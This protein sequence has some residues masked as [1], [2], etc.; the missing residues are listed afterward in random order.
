MVAALDQDGLT[1]A[2]LLKGTGIDSQSVR[3]YVMDDNSKFHI[4]SS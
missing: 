2:C 1:I 3:V 4:F